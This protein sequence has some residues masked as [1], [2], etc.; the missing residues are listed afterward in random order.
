MQVVLSPCGDDSSVQFVSS[1]AVVN[2]GV[3]T[4]GGRVTDT[5]LLDVLWTVSVPWYGG[6]G[7]M[8]IQQALIT[9][10]EE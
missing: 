8:E 1:T 4:V 9:S 10:T 5:L 7:L 2:R 3:D 6:N